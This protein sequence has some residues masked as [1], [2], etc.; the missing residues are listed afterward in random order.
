MQHRGET[1]GLKRGYTERASEH[2]RERRGTV[3]VRE[4][5]ECA[6]ERVVQAK[7]VSSHVE[8]E[9]REIQGVEPPRVLAPLPAAIAEPPEEREE[10]REAKADHDIAWRERLSREALVG[11]VHDRID[12]HRNDREPQK[13]VDQRPGRGMRRTQDWK[14]RER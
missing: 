7:R 9:D 12:A 5:V 13:N 14:T 8:R 10:H 1:H 4:V 6:G 11:T 2:D 3:R